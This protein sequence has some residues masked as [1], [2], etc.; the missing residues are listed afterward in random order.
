[1]PD[2]PKQPEP[3]RL[4]FNPAAMADVVRWF[5]DQPMPRPTAE[6]WAEICRENP[7]LEP[8]DLNQL[9]PP[10]TRPKSYQAN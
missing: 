10:D 6:K 5:M 3:E 4:P 8:E 9:F 7:G 2:E 1:V